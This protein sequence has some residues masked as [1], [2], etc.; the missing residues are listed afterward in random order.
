[1]HLIM[2]KLTSTK[3]KVVYLKRSSER[4]STTRLD[5]MSDQMSS[6][7]QHNDFDDLSSL[8]SSFRSSD[9][10]SL[11]DSSARS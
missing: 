11:G 1:M 10:H 8:D 5:E 3:R 4:N 2:S 9:D 6:P 7:I